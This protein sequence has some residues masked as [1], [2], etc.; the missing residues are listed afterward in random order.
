M[1]GTEFGLIF[2]LRRDKSKG[3]TWPITLMAVLAALFLA[4]GVLRHYLDVYVHRS[5][6]GI[7]FIFCGIDALG[8]L[9]SLIAVLF[10]PELDILGMV[11][12]GVELVLWIGIFA[13]GGW[14]NLRP[15]LNQKLSS[16]VPVQVESTSGPYPVREQADEIAGSVG[17][18]LQDLPS[19]TSA[20]RTS[21]TS[22]DTVGAR[23]L[24]M[25]SIRNRVL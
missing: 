4:L 7:S 21:S 20:F 17:I 5:V 13:C 23:R 9:T 18:P 16:K 19:S 6:R 14:Y 22:V 15:W 3:T 12:Y 24:S 8:D 10:Q 2:A 1:A 25:Q 11:I